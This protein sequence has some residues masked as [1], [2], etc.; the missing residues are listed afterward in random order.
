LS[1]NCIEYPLVLFGATMLGAK[2]TTINPLY[3]PDEIAKQLWDS[4]ATRLVA[5]GGPLLDNARLAI[6]KGV[7]IEGL[8][9][10]GDDAPAG[11]G[12]VP[13]AEPFA[14]LLAGGAPAPPPAD[15]DPNEHVACMPY[16]SG[17][18][19][20]PKGV[21]LTHSNIVS[22]VLQLE[23]GQTAMSPSDVLV[24]VLPFYH[25]YG[26]TVIMNVALA[27]GSA[28]VTLPRF[29]PELFLRVLKEHNVTVA[30][31]APPLVGF[32]AK[33]PAVESILPLP[34]LKELFSGAAPLG[35]DLEQAAKARLG[36]MVRQGYGMTEA[37]PATHVVPYDRAADARGSVG[38]LVPGMECKIVR[39]EDGMAAGVG[40]RG[41]ICLKGPNVMKGYLNRPDATAESFDED[42]FY[43]TGDI[44]YVDADDMFFVVDRVK[45]LIKCKGFQVAPAE[46]EGVL[47]GFEAIADAAVIGVPD[48]KHGEV[49]KAYVVR[50]KGAEGLT[51]EEVEAFLR[52]RVA[53]YKQIAAR[54]VEFVDA[55]PKSAAGKILRKELRAIEEGRRS[56][57][58][59]A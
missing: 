12:D 3:T 18:S 16:S 13:T 38:T 35:E 55:V 40:E 57:V 14:A 33:H 56:A 43:K 44:G 47:V 34:H 15:F 23:V 19:G 49:P 25:I 59:A 50:Q 21:E 46:L 45:E 17:T 28:V 39:T 7:P 31:V 26:L 51:G 8:Y 37:A 6:A 41:E 10:L 36:C 27:A 54:H 32:L 11:N 53:E 48:S 1:P 22:N 42:G 2:V 30:H 29:D 4:G 58:S 20:L 5:T 9:V 24:G 52:G